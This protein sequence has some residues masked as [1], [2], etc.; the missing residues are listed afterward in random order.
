HVQRAVKS[1]NEAD[2]PP[3]S[4]LSTVNVASSNS[5]VTSST[6]GSPSRRVTAG[7]PMTAVASDT[8]CSVN[9]HTAFAGRLHTS[10]YP[11]LGVSTA[12]PSFGTV[13]RCVRSG[14]VQHSTTD[15]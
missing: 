4:L 1:K 5:R 9:V 2:A 15:E 7:E 11:S 10:E 3:S 8:E 6:C 14:P 13:T 12:T